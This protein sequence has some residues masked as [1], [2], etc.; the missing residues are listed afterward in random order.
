VT[1]VV[2]VGFVELAGVANLG[3]GPWVALTGATTAIV[4]EVS[5]KRA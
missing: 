4:A 3:L 2:F 5:R 1:A